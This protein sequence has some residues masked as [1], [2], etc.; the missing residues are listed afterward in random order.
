MRHT[1][2][3]C[4]V[5]ISIFM[6]LFYVIPYECLNDDRCPCATT[7][8]SS[9]RRCTTMIRAHYVLMLGVLLALVSGRKPRFDKKK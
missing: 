4:V 7:Y 1:L 9:G 6:A 5:S 8:S 2:G 3:C